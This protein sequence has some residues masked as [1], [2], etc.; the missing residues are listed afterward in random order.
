MR[1]MKYF[2]LIIILLFSSLIFSQNTGTIFGKIVDK[3]AE[4]TPL[5]FADITIKNT[6]VKVS[7]DINGLFII[8]NLEDGEYTLICSFLGYETQEL[9]FTLHP[10]EP[11]VINLSLGATTFS[12]A[13]FNT[14]IDTAKKEPESLISHIK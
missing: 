3:E 6:K 11:S 9:S 13:E 7:S 5:A 12:F 8:E 4:N 2:V 1:I 10:L 14:L